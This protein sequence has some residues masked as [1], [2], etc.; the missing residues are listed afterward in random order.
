MANSR[1]EA[2]AKK[3]SNHIF[4]IGPVSKTEKKV[5]EDRILVITDVFI[6]FYIEPRLSKTR[7]FWSDITSY[8]FKH[9]KIKFGT[10]KDTLQLTGQDI[11]VID[12]QFRILLQGSLSANDFSMT[13]AEPLRAPALSFGNWGPLGRYAGLCMKAKKPPNPE[14]VTTLTGLLRTSAHS[15]D[16]SKYEFGPKWNENSSPLYESLSLIPFLEQLIVKKQK[17]EKDRSVNVLSELTKN[18]PKFLTLQ[19]LS[20]E[21]FERKWKD[22]CDGLKRSPIKSLTIQSGLKQS[23]FGCLK[24]IQLT[25]LTVC[26]I[27]FKDSPMPKFISEVLIPLSS[28]TV[29]GLQGCRKVS[30]KDIVSALPNLTSLSL[31]ECK[32]EV[33]ESITFTAPLNSLRALCLAK[34]KGS[35]GLISEWPTNLIRL[36]LMGVHWTPET[37]KTFWDSASGRTWSGGAEF[38]IQK[39]AFK[40]QSGEQKDISAFWPILVSVVPCSI[41]SWCWD[42]TSVDDR[43]WDFLGQC[44]YLKR[45]VF[46][47]AFNVSNR[48]SIHGLIRI[49]PQLGNLRTLIITS[50]KGDPGSIFISLLDALVRSPITHLDVSYSRSGE[51][52]LVKLAEL[53]RENGQLQAVTFDSIKN[54]TYIGLQTVLEA[55]EQRSAKLLLSWPDKLIGR[56]NLD[57]E[58]VQKLRVRFAKVQGFPYTEEKDI[59]CGLRSDYVDSGEFPKFPCSELERILAIPLNNSLDLPQPEG[60]DT[61]TPSLNQKHSHS[62]SSKETMSPFSSP[63]PQSDSDD[64]KQT[65]SPLPS[66]IQQSESSSPQDKKQSPLPSPIQQ[67]DSDDS[68]QTKSPLPKPRQHSDSNS[69]KE[70]MSPLPQPIQQSGSDSSK[71]TKS[72]PPKP[73]RQSDSESRDDKE[74][75][76]PKLI[77]QSDSDSNRPKSPSP[78]MITPVLGNSGD[79]ISLLPIKLKSGTVPILRPTT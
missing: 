8:S 31:I 20:V 72:P 29:F 56:L 40:G 22:F 30:V 59:V 6:A 27:G 68:K 41:T 46:H 78:E 55:A 75:L 63:I 76:P 2:S 34:N 19:H 60:A 25:S 39:L 43:L 13:Q 4:F 23:N 71:E 67:S 26:G 61:S 52:G 74:T 73:L 17:S 50:K 62:D 21:V 33:L 32:L 58:D 24:G 65:K 51:P 38:S 10:A 77:Q 28:L 9:E 1:V 54:A 42:L 16:T 15:F 3:R 12:R 53:I 49:L 69:S 66:P 45:L 57:E 37:L 11:H 14:I 70:I 5:H 36:D 79:R 48:E 7:Y 44:R 64:S 35:K 18:L 47:S